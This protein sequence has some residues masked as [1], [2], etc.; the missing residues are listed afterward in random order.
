M[1]GVSFELS[2]LF[3]KSKTEF[4]RRK[5]CTLQVD[6]N[7]I[8]Q[9]RCRRNCKNID[10]K[11]GRVVVAKQDKYL[12]TIGDLRSFP[13]EGVLTTALEKL[14]FMEVKNE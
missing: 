1:V 10:H 14:R 7:L 4:S 5:L 9:G 3:T 12:Q 13:T 2:V 8:I 6:P 11:H